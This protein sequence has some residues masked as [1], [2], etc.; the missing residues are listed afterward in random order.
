MRRD[1]TN[2]AAGL[3]AETA[4]A[5]LLRLKGYRIVAR[6][7]R[8]PVGEVDLIVRRRGVLAFVEVKR[9]ARLDDALGAAT[10]FMRG[11]IERAAQFFLARH[12][13]L[14]DLTLRFDLVAVAPFLRCRHLDN[15]WRPAS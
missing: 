8:T 12:P 7:F 3:A 6:R 1:A 4:A 15:A 10:P 13:H 5:V 2:H 9:R 11:R 14:A